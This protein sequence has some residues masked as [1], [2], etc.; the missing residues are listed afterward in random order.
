MNIQQM[1]MPAIVNEDGELVPINQAI[2]KK[3]I[4]DIPDNQLEDM[5][6]TVKMFD[7]QI[8]IVKSEM[9][10]RA[11]DGHS[12]SRYILSD[13]ANNKLDT[14]NNVF[15]QEMQ[16]KYGWDALE[17]KSATQLKRQFGDQ[18]TQDIERHTVRGVRQVAEWQ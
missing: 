6:Y 14:D 12:F 17:V 10:Q 13:R 8:N 7:P 3:N 9:K 2:N 11:K 1:Q 16:L 15:K 4:K 5:A 18:V